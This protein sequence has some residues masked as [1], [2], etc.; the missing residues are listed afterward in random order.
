MAR[1]WLNLSAAAEV[2]GVHPSTVRNWANQGKLPV[3]RTQGGHRRFLASELELWNKSDRADGPDEAALVVQNALGY[4]RFQIGEGLLEAEEWYGKLDRRARQAYSRR[5]RDLM[6]GLITYI[7]AEQDVANAEARNQ[8]YQHAA[9]SRRYNLSVSE[10]V[11][12]FLFFRNV[13][14]ESMMSVYE[15]AVVTSPFVWGDMLRK[16]SSFTDQI[17]LA[18]LDTYHVFEN[19]GET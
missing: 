7:S 4:T 13:L 11:Q 17:L 19:Q 9:L 2:L 5:G 6:R 14:L 12:A 18:L 3:H 1:K 16:T 15:S 10:A 8:G